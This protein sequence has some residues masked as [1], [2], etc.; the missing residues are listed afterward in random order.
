[1]SKQPLANTVCVTGE[2]NRTVLFRALQEW[3]TSVT[4]TRAACVSRREQL[5][6]MQPSDVVGGATTMVRTLVLLVPAVSVTV[7]RTV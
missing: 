3:L 7:R 6:D 4:V 2:V 1:M 5:V